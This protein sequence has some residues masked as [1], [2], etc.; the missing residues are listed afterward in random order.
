MYVDQIANRLV[1]RRKLLVNGVV[2]DGGAVW[3]V[4]SGSIEGVGDVF[5]SLE[6]ALLSA[7]GNGET[8]SAGGRSLDSCLNAVEADRRAAL[9]GLVTEHGRAAG[10]RIDHFVGVGAGK[11]NRVGVTGICRHVGDGPGAYDP[12][13]AVAGHRLRGKGAVAGGD[14]HED[15]GPGVVRGDLPTGVDLDQSLRRVSGISERAAGI[16]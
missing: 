15:V 16:L 3:R 8:V 1:E 2:Q 12:G 11:L 13:T 9:V 7:R 5:K 4:G 6:Y 10:G 14:A